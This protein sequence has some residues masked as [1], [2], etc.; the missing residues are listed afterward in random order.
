VIAGEHDVVPTR[1]RRHLARVREQPLVGGRAARTEEFLGRHWSARTGAPS[2][3][4]AHDVV[5]L[6]RREP[7]TRRDAFERGRVGAPR[8]QRAAPEILALAGIRQ[9]QL[10]AVQRH[11]EHALQI[12]EPR[13]ARK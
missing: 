6:A 11:V 7:E 9:G 12:P 8:I 10:G 4:T 13:G 5:D 3:E 1:A 2:S